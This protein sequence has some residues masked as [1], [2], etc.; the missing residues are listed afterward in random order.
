MNGTKMA[1]LMA[2][3][4]TKKGVQQLG[5]L[6]VTQKQF[7]DFLSTMGEPDTPNINELN[8]DALRTRSSESD[9]G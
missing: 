8:L 5:R 9:G 6:Q 7:A 1:Q 2:V 3:Q 4:T